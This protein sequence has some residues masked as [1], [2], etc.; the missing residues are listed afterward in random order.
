[1]MISLSMRV[2]QQ[3][4]NDKQVTKQPHNEEGSFIVMPMNFDV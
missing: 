2:L 1:M 3:N 4:E